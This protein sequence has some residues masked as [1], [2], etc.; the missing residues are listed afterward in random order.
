MGLSA[1]LEVVKLLLGHAD[2]DANRGLNSDGETAL[3]EAAE[4]NR[5]DF[6]QEILKDGSVD[7]NKGS[8]ACA[9][10]SDARFLHK[11]HLIIGLTAAAV[12][13]GKDE[14]G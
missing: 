4:D 7:V 9:N 3:I 14:N 5:K 12:Q 1:H 6:V 2:I 13:P 10:W 11:F 8:T